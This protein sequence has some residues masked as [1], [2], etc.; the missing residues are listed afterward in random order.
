MLLFSTS[1]AAM[2]ITGTAG[3]LEYEKNKGAG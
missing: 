1:A 2:I 3:V